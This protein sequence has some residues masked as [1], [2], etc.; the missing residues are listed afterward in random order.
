MS[1]TE[2]AIALR[3]DQ[4][5]LS[6]REI[7]ANPDAA[8]RFAK[9]LAMGTGGNQADAT[10]ALAKI[11]IGA[12]MGIG[13]GAA[14]RGMHFIKGRIS[15]SADLMVGLAQEDGCSFQVEHSDPPGI[16]C[17]VTGRRA[18]GTTY[19]FTWTMAM[20]RNA[21][22]A[23]GDNWKKYPWDMLYARAAAHV[24]R[25]IAPGRLLGMYTAD[26]LDASIPA[27]AKAAPSVPL[28]EVNPTDDAILGDPPA[29]PSSDDA[30]DALWEPSDD[31]KEAMRR[32]EVIE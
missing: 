20:A 30:Q 17:K 1:T 29:A 24:A 7:Y 13:P 18:D 32:E 10:Q 21:G 27:D 26:E 11:V 31:E 19:S 5:K 14:V 8:F 6:V 9:A 12:E 4:N 16:H 28:I 15:M 2:T 23:G 3:T 25:K 22:L